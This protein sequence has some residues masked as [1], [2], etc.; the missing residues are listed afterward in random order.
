M[1]ADE[2]HVDTII[3]QRRNYHSDQKTY[4]SINSHSRC[5]NNNP[6]SNNNSMSNPFNQE[7]NNPY[8]QKGSQMNNNDG[9]PKGDTEE[10]NPYS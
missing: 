9:F 6:Y 4:H 8:E 5:N 2:K 1:L 7:G 3:K 10:G